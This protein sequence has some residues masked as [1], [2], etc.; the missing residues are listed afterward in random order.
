MCGIS[1]F[2]GNG[3]LN[4][5]KAMNNMMVHRG[6]ETE[7]Y[8]VG[9]EN[10]VFLGH[11]RLSIIDIEGGFQPMSSADERLVIVF[12]GEIYNFPEL[13]KTLAEK[14]YPFQTDHSD[15]EVLIYGYREWGFDLPNHLNGMWAFAIYDKEKAQLFISRDRFGKKPFFYTLQQGLFAFASELSALIKHPE[16]HQSFS[17]KSLKKYFA[18]GYIPSPNTIYEG[19]C[20]LPGGYNLVFDLKKF[21][22]KIDRYWEFKIEPVETIPEN[23]EN[24]WGEQLRDLIDKA[25]CR[26]LI[27]D[28][29]L[30]VFASG[31]IDSSSIAY[32]AIKHKGLESLGTFS[33]GFE[34]AT[35]DESFYSKMIAEKLGTNHHLQV[36][37][38]EKAQFLLPEI[39]SKLDEPMGDSSLIPTYMLCK[40]TKKF[41]TVAVGGDGADELFAGYDPFR[42][43]KMAELYSKLIPGPLHKAILLM[44]NNIPTS[45]SNMSLDFKLKRTLRGLSYGRNIWNPVWMGTLAPD[46]LSVLFNEEIDTEDVYSEAI[47]AWDRCRGVNIF[48]KILEFYT[49][50]YL[51][52]DILVKIDRASMMNSLEVRAP[53]LDIDLVNFVRTI[54]WQYKYRNGE[55]K[56]IL[57]KALEPIL[58]KE[59]LYRPKKG[60]GVPIGKW[61]REGSIGISN[62]EGFDYLD[63]PFISKKIAEHR[64]GKADHRA[65]L[66][67]LLLLENKR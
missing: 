60:F 52:D 42:A 54:P 37:S 19:I 22:A 63:A 61:F 27:S 67:N 36:L 56:Y 59:I 49:K 23:P 55:T 48:D 29:P 28:V 12:N 21:T 58:P 25:V 53:Y 57:K 38:L 39:I 5:L 65:F 66:W 32:Y 11:R 9:E 31:G 3:C 47:E 2:A 35:F 62:P 13:R 41:V 4:D 20:K 14:G 15:T 17:L 46:E 30:G 1:G 6:P 50:L 16:I 34:E 45:Y 7:G 44:V 18:Y 8:F 33:I 43:L 24:V 51:Q 10:R 40:E 64:S 26:R